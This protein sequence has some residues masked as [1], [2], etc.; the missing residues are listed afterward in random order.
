MIVTG[1]AQGIGRGVAMRG[2][3][4][5]RVVLVDRATLVE[6]VA[7][8]IVAAGGTAIP[9]MPTWRRSGAQAMVAAATGLRPVDIL[10]NNV[11]GTIWAKPFEHYARRRSRPSPPLAVSHAVGCRAVLPGM[12]ERRRASSSTFRPSP[13]AAS[14]ACP[15]RRPRAAS[16]R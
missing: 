11:G 4:R 1:A 5:A 3:R 7:A 16:M 10:V 6:E 13:R 14:T 8:E 9:S 12:L 15:T 2:G